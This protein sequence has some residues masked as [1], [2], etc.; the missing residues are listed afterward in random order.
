MMMK[1]DGMTSN[2]AGAWPPPEQGVSKRAEREKLLA[3]QSPAFVIFE[4]ACP[5]CFGDLKEH[6][7]GEWTQ[8]GLTRKWY[9]FQCVGDCGKLWFVEQ[10]R[11][12]D[13]A[14]N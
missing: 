11:D 6:D 2:W 10:T 3:G 7:K 4:G 8:G 9:E 1:N 14:T 5:D 13:W 12:G